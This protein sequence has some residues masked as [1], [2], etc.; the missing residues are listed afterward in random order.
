METKANTTLIG[1]FTL[2]V[3]AV[4]GL[5][6]WWFLRA[7]DTTVRTQYGI[8]FPG[9][10]AGLKPGASV[11]F[12]GLRVGDVR[13]VRVDP[14]DPRQVLGVISVA[15]D[16]PVRSNTRVSLDVAL[17]SGVAA[18]SLA[19]GSADAPPL[20]PPAPGEL[21]ML[22]ADPSAIQDLLQGAR[23]IMTNVDNLVRRLDDTIAAGQGG[24]DRSL[25]NV[26]RFTQALGDNADNINT[27]LSQVGGISKRLD[28]ILSQI[29]SVMQ[30]TEPGRVASILRN[31]DDLTRGLA[32]QTDSFAE[33]IRE[34]KTA[35]GSAGRTLA[36]L[37][38]DRINRSFANIERFTQTL[39]DNSANVDQIVKNAAEVSAK[40]NG[41]ADRVDALLRSFDGNGGNNMFAEFTNTARSIRTLAER[42]DTRTAQLSNS[43]SGFTDRTLRDI[44]SLSADGRR[45]LSELDRT[46]RALER[47]PQRF[48]FGGSGVPE[49]RR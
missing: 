48:I 21:P 45:T 10:V 7:G 12:N 20:V 42:L 38:A 35:F 9:A 33:L 5:F 36:A 19:G 41:M 3:L 29:E 46:L 2:A 37:D 17:L 13:S 15:S 40:L 11:Y 8:V 32:S 39:G 43:I 28:V 25:R 47:N 27:F 22:R 44:Q 34:A 30:G 4:F 23:Q 18:V 16:T 31:V 26:E 49:Y 6:L 24:F 14:K 1:A